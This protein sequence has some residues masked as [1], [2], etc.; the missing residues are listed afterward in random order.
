MDR[1]AVE[2][3]TEKQ[4]SLITTDQFLTA[5]RSEGALRW[6]L[7]DRWLERYEAWRGLYIVC[8]SPRTPFQPHMAATLA[9]GERGAAGGFAA[10]WLWG[11]PDIAES[12]PEVTVFGPARRI[13]GATVRRSQ[14]PAGRW[15]VERHGIRTVDA[16]L[17]VVEL[18]R[19]GAGYL[20]E[21]VANDFFKRHITHPAAILEGVELAGKRRPGCA[22][23]RAFCERALRV[24]G[25]DDSPAARDLGDAL[26]RA[27]V[28][29]FVTQHPVTVEGRL[30][31]LDFAWPEHRVALEYNGW[32]DHGATR[33][34][35]DN[36]AAR[37]SRLAAA[38]WRVL[39]ATSA[40]G[41]DSV[42]RWVLATLTAAR[43]P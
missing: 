20:A 26:L 4:H 16:P 6:A 30:Y 41:H 1:R 9:A 8:G 31:I 23:L 24:R 21:R 38:G 5:T 2:L 29:P 11:A 15:I 40:A 14:L 28:P 33:N 19:L 13:R 37:R 32:A 22:D 7:A 17:V 18:A 35:F 42:I 43:F 34:S 39:D 3:I 10:A 12:P 27:G 25:H 36:D